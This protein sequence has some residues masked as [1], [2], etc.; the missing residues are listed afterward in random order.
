MQERHVHTNVDL[1]GNLYAC[2][3][4]HEPIGH[5]DGDYAEYYKKLV[6]GSESLKYVDVCMDCYVRDL[7]RGWVQ[8]RAK[9]KS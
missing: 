2:H 1:D 9:R 4:V 3:N 6:Q 7:C 5:V 8:A